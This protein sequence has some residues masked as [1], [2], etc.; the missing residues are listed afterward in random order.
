MSLMISPTQ[1]ASIPELFPIAPARW[2]VCSVMATHLNGCGQEQ[3]KHDAY[4]VWRTSRSTAATLGMYGSLV[5]ML[6]FCLYG[7]LLVNVHKHL[8]KHAIAQSIIFPLVVY[9]ECDRKYIST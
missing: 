8:I 3:T 4:K 1:T 6:H 5:K 7:V 9:P 2:L